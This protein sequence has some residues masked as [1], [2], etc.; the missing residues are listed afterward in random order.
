MILA[1]ALARTR[2]TSQIVQCLSNTRRLMA[3]WQMY[4]ADNNG[5]IVVNLHGGSAMGGTGD[6]VYGM[7]W[8]EGWLDWTYSTDNT[9]V[10]FLVNGRYSK[11]APYLSRDA[12][13]LFVCPANVYLTS[14][15]RLS[16]WT[17]RARTYSANIGIGAGNAEAGPWDTMYNH[18]LKD[19]DFR[20]PLP[21]ETW[22]FI[23]E[24][25]DSLNDPAFF[26]PHTT[27]WI[28][29]P[30][31]FHNGGAG[32]AFADGHSEIHRWSASLSRGSPRQ[33]SF[34][35]GIL[36]IPL[37]TPKDADIG[38]MVHHGGTFNPSTY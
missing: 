14:V 30:S 13:N 8:A 24:H 6:A 25:P 5:K 17:R 12:T 19:A 31:T 10:Q 27:G 18:I 35:A 29:T 36:S 32:F 37:N 20:Y 4:S 9:N 34:T 28:D 15:Q 26:N 2:P 22:V 33:V 16:G 21:S 3:A 7:S 1:P 23:D 11:L 38:W